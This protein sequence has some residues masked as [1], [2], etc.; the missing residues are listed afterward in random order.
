MMLP[1]ETANAFNE[2][3]RRYL[4]DP[5]RFLRE[6]EEIE[7]FKLEEKIGQEPSYGEVCAKYLEDLLNGR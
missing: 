2:W 6:W 5:A 1:L 7:H 3:M 4:E